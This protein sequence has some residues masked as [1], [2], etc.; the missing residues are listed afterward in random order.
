MGLD[1]DLAEQQPGI[2]LSQ[3]R[4]AVMQL[5]TEKQ[6]QLLDLGGRDHRLGLSQAAGEIGNLIGKL[7]PPEPQVD[8]PFARRGI[9]G[10]HQPLLDQFQQPRN[11]CLG[12]LVVL[13][14]LTQ[15]IRLRSSRSI[16]VRR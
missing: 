5:I 13:A 14:H 2:G 3:I 4:L 8:Q 1:T 11:A 15:S 10:V 7:I 9:L 16:A 12:F 6:C